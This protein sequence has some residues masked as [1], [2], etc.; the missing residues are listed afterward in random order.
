MRQS[1]PVSSLNKYAYNRPSVER[2]NASQSFDIDYHDPLSN[3]R[4]GRADAF[5][6]HD[7]LD[8]VQNIRRERTNAFESH[9]CFDPFLNIRPERTTTPNVRWSSTPQSRTPGLAES[10]KKWD[11]SDYSTIAQH[12]I[13]AMSQIE[14]IDVNEFMKKYPPN[15]PDARLSEEAFKLQQQHW[16]NY[17]FS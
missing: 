4:S 7:H 17:Q 14:S 3:I 10:E 16:Q 13:L 6:S 1:Q 8:P 12:Q 2:L 9:D 15:T 11:L 5:E